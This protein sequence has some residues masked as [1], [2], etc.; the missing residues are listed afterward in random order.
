MLGS[1]I[2]D[3]TGN[4]YLKS[5]LT[6]NAKSNINIKLNNTNNI[7]DNTTN[8]YSNNVNNKSL[9]RCN[10]GKIKKIKKT[11]NFPEG[12]ICN[13]NFSN[14]SEEIEAEKLSEIFNEYGLVETNENK[15]QCL[16][17]LEG[18]EKEFDS[19]KKMYTHLVT[20]C[21]FFICRLCTNRIKEE[22]NLFNKEKEASRSCL[23]SNI[24]ILKNKKDS[25]LNITKNNNNNK[26]DVI[27]NLLSIR[28]NKIV[29][30]NNFLK[31]INITSISINQIKHTSF[32][33][34]NSNI[35]IHNN[36]HPINILNLLSADNNLSYYKKN[37]SEETNATNYRKLCE[38]KDKGC[39]FKNIITGTNKFCLSNFDFIT[40]NPESF[41][42]KC[43][44]NIYNISTNVNDIGNKIS[45]FDNYKNL[46]SINSNMNI[47]DIVENLNNG[48]NKIVKKKDSLAD[49]SCN[50][51]Y[52]RLS[53]AFKPNY[54]QTK[55]DCLNENNSG[56][57]I[58]KC[59]LVNAKN[60]I[61]MHKYSKSDL[62][63]NEAI[64]SINISPIDI[65]HT[66]NNNGIKNL[67]L[68]DFSNT[69]SKNRPSNY[70]D[71]D[72]FRFFNIIDNSPKFNYV[73]MYKSECIST[74]E[75]NNTNENNN[76]KFKLF[77]K[78]ICHFK[79]NNQYNCN[80]LILCIEIIDSAGL[81]ITGHEN[82]NICLYKSDININSNNNKETY[83]NINNNKIGKSF[84]SN[85][86]PFHIITS[87]Q[88]DEIIQCKVL[89][90]TS[91]AI[92]LFRENKLVY[93]YYFTAINRKGDIKIYEIEILIKSKI[94]E[95]NNNE[96]NDLIAYNKQDE[97]NNKVS[98][99]FDL[100]NKEKYYLISKSNNI[101]DDANLK[102]TTIL[103][104]INALN[105]KENKQKSSNE[106]LDFSLKSK[107]IS[108]LNS[109][110]PGLTNLAIIKSKY[111]ENINQYENL[112]NT[113]TIYTNNLKKN[114][115]LKFY[116]HILVNKFGE[117]TSCCF[118]NQGNSFVK[119]KNL[120]KFFY[121]KD[122]IN[123]VVYN[124]KH[125]LIITSSK[126]YLI[127]WKWNMN[128]I[129][130]LNNKQFNCYFL[131]N[132]SKTSKEANTELLET[133][134]ISIENIKDDN[135]AALYNNNNIV[136]YNYYSYNAIIIIN[137]ENVDKHLKILSFKSLLKFS[138]NKE[139]HIK[140]S[141]ILDNKEMLILKINNQL[142]EESKY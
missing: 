23:N 25:N 51:P 140:L 35:E 85:T 88:N 36:N 5:N 44:S 92:N 141:I 43:Y 3:S 127:A 97:Q 91:K 10:I 49:I 101:N 83:N 121:K 16:M 54:N 1:I 136:V 109:Y 105:T 71:F 132:K 133:T 40:D 14:F 104:Q 77:G 13:R 70:K 95:I 7:T 41:S 28:E 76:I 122:S 24:L 78:N 98:T 39:L 46:K 69:F 114:F 11:N 94:N 73:D 55:S 58:N 65:K 79:H 96:D 131:F 22:K 115:D 103:Q 57:S 93:Y 112:L 130:G 68:Y 33:N 20:E 125:D 29:Y 128:K 106:V 89:N 67:E 134:I 47:E 9:I 31:K 102:N 138:N 26:F 75:Y 45:T 56:K 52:S 126:N 119:S 53:S 18:C 100:I 17:E 87:N 117:I 123:E 142:L 32:V 37:S 111:I 135:I 63:N 12:S 137:T 60:K 30:N 90:K 116:C 15:Y 2:N 21:N 139:N 99:N 48:Y 61:N 4:N 66:R 84:K 82:G 74:N 8:I 124:N 72:K 27:Y 110:Y 38:N 6:G 50:Q 42:N 118:D 108:C 34:L 107:Q 86:H 59:S 80:S 113:N 129:E 81:I 62:N 19:K 64:N 120:K